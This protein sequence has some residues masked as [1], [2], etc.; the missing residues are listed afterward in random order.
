MVLREYR[1]SLPNNRDQ[2]GGVVHDI[3]KATDAGE[4]NNT[5]LY[6]VPKS[7]LF[8]MGDNRDNSADSRFWGDVPAVNLVGKAEIIFF[9]VD[10]RDPWWQFWMWPFEIRWGRIGMIIS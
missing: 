1:E 4:A 8:V 7:E 9:S 2:P 5:P 10:G 6:S 3:L